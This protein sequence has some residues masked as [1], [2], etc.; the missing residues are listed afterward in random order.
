[1]NSYEA[2]AKTIN[3]HTVRIARRLRLSTNM[4][5][6]WQEPST[7]FTDSGALNPLDRIEEIIDEALK[8]NPQDAFTPIYW[9]AEQFNL[10]VISAPDS[11]TGISELTEELLKTINEF[12]DLTKASSMALSADSPGG[13]KITRDEAEKINQEGQEVIRQVAAFLKT[14]KKLS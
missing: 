3:R 13:N 5:N 4:V 12:S 7:D 2:L 6:K 1:M 10:I 11:P 8:L 14:V 9:L